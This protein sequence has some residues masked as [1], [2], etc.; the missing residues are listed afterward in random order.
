MAADLLKVK[1]GHRRDAYVLFEP[2]THKYTIISTPGKIDAISV[3]ELL[4]TMSQKFD[5]ELLLEERYEIWQVPENQSKYYGMPKAEIRNLWLDKANEARELGKSFHSMIEEWCNGMNPVP[6]HSVLPEWQQFMKFQ[7]DEGLRPF[8]TEMQVWSEEHQLA[9]TIDCLSS[10]DDGTFTLYDWKRSNDDLHR[11]KCWNRYLTGPLRHYHIPDNKR[12]HY[13]LQL[14]LYRVLLQR[15]YQY[16]ISHMFIVK[17][18]HKQTQYHRISV[19]DWSTY[20][21]IILSSRLQQVKTYKH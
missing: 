15:Y 12:S 16:S 18:H 3:T 8:R 14:N 20:I 7:Q 10:N 5:L 6:H 11:Y 21:D 2:E 4:G 13:C 9:G 19:P 1:N 17:F